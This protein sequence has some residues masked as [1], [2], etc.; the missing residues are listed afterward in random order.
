MDN[1]NGS[2]DLLKTG[3]D[4]INVEYELI[5]L[6]DD[7]FAELEE[8]DARLKELSE[9]IPELD[10]EIDRL[11]NRADGLDYFASVASGVVSALVD[12]F[13]VGSI[14]GK[15]GWEDGWKKGWKEE[16]A[17]TDNFFKKIVIW[18]AN[19]KAKGFDSLSEEDKDALFK[20]AL[21]ILEKK[22]PLPSDDAY[23]VLQNWRLPGT[24]IN[25]DH[26]TVFSAPA[27]LKN[28]T[29]ISIS[30]PALHHIDDLCHHPT[31]VGFVAC[32]LSILFRSAFFIDKNGKWHVIRIIDKDLKERQAWLWSCII[33]SGFL[34]WL[35]VLAKNKA[36][37]DY[38]KQLPTPLCRLLDL[39]ATS[40]T[41]IE[42][43][44]VFNDW[45]GHLCSDF[46]GSSGSKRRG[47]GIPGILLSSLKELLAIPPFNKIPGLHKAL[48]RLFLNGFD[49]RAEATI[50]RLSG[51]QAVP[52]ILNEF[53]VRGFYSV[54][55]LIIEARA[56][57]EDWNSYNWKEII[58]F[59]NSTVV[60]MLTVAHGTFAAIDFA[61]AA[62]RTAVSKKHVD[63]YSFLATMALRVNF[64][65]IGRFS[66]AV[67]SDIRVGWQRGNKEREYR[68]I[69]SEILPYYN[70]KVFFKEAGMWKEASLTTKRGIETII[71]IK[72]TELF[73]EES[74]ISI[75]K[76][77]EKIPSLQ[78]IEKNDSELAEQL[79]NN[80]E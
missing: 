35:V 9:K 52:V 16:L 23:D 59:S 26:I 56:Y 42:L 13:F 11:T 18:K 61:D 3:I 80:L 8:I 62:A 74:L 77:L 37:N 57:G 64:V 31:I 25:L 71:A 43:L 36:K 60:R 32:V 20:K 54:R 76:D 24:K 55:R 40:P 30:T 73:L 69:Y 15:T 79:K 19:L 67:F 2:I 68:T 48:D 46:A 27:D 75:K 70:A 63:F 50:L 22:Y 47:M 5:C 7:S 14:L 6:E 10:K 34:K 49:A 41:A 28:K 72:N 45:L 39:L 21:R 58:P 44:I 4:G 33:L 66:I 17:K 12:S 1:H 29:R 78:E 51:K 38:S 53:L 65:G